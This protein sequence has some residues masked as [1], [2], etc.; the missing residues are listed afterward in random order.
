MTNAAFWNKAAPK[1][2]K[3]AIGDMPAYEETLDRMRE[4]LQPHHRVLELGCGTGSTALELADSVDR[5]IG[6]DVASKMVKIAK[7]KLTEQSPQNL[8]FAV[9]DAG[10]MTSGSNDVVLA[11]N[12]LHLLPDLE[13]TLA[14][15]YK[16]L[17]SGGLLISKTG[18]LKDGLWLLP[19]VIPLMRTIGKAPFVRSLSE[20][21]L[22]GLLE[23]AGFKVTENLVQG[24]MVP[25]VFI[26]AQKP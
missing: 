9:Q 7:G 11:L 14:E 26:V 20:E 2:A 6:T 18:L 25:R 15:I 4:I 22:I 3:D 5:Y 1:Y 21:S 10:V 24:G 17:P 19:L 16:A 8:S 23:N 12:L 13:N